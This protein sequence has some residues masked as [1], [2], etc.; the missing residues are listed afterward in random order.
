MSSRRTT[1]TSHRAMA[2]SGTRADG[3]C[4]AVLGMCGGAPR[5]QHRQPQSAGGRSPVQPGRAG[6][7]AGKG[8]RRREKEHAPSAPA[9][10]LARVEVVFY[11]E[12][13]DHRGLPHRCE[14]MRVPRE[15]AER[16]EAIAAAIYEFEQ[17]QCVSHWTIAADG[18][19]VETESA[20]V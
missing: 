13:L 4:G 19:E 14:L 16:D 12:I 7:A 18:Y 11:K 6:R 9:S 20:V 15:S 1:Q 8:S 10:A 5:M 2:H 3:A 17:A